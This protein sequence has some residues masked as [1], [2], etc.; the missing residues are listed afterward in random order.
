MSDNKKR[1]KKIIFFH[2]FLFPSKDLK[3]IDMQRLIDYYGEAV[4][5][6][7]DLF[8]GMNIT[9]KIDN[10]GQLLLF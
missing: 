8:C 5:Y 7:Y 3:N 2:S 1:A 6:Q 10:G 9:V 4:A